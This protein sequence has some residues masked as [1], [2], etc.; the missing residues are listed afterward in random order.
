MSEERLEWMFID[1]IP[2][3]EVNPKKHDEGAMFSS[4]R[5]Y[6]FIEKPVM[7]ETTGRL[8]AGHGRIT[9]LM[10]MYRHNDTHVPNGVRVV[11]GRWQVQVHRG[12]YFADE[13]E[14]LSYLIDSNNIGTM[15]GELTSLDRS[16]MWDEDIYL[17]LLNALAQDNTLPVSTDEH[18]VD[19]LNKILSEENNQSES[20]TKVTDTS[21][22]GDIPLYRIT[23]ECDSEEQKESLMDRLRGE[24]YLCR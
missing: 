5:R 8:V 23:V 15:G 14:A 19:F 7:N 17:E 24:G 21:V 13:N 2:F 3:A 20:D 16:K 22:D 18:D 10:F 11:D 9:A 4:I 6:G 1:E 12:V